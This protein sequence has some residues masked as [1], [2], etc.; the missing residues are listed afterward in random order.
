MVDGSLLFYF[1]IC[2]FFIAMYFIM[3]NVFQ[4][5]PSPSLSL[6]LSVLYPKVLS[7]TLDILENNI[8]VLILALFH[9]V[10]IGNPGLVIPCS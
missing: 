7:Q 4:Y 9:A 6:G 2:Y 8:V 10:A 1:R 5:G 3:L